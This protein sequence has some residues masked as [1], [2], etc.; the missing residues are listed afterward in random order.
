MKKI[1][2]VVLLTLLTIASLSTS[3]AQTPRPV[4]PP[5]HPSSQ[6]A[7]L[8][9][10]TFG[11]TQYQHQA[12]QLLQSTV[13]SLSSSV[14]V[15]N[16]YQPN[17]FSQSGV[18][19]AL[20]FQSE[21]S[22]FSQTRP[23]L[24]G[25]SGISIGVI[26][27]NCLIAMV[28]KDS[29]CDPRTGKIINLVP[30]PQS[31]IPKLN[32]CFFITLSK[33]SYC[34][35]STGKIKSFFKEIDLNPFGLIPYRC[36]VAHFVDGADCYHSLPIEELTLSEQLT[37]P[38]MYALF[39]NLKDCGQ[40]IQGSMG[41]PNPDVDVEGDF[42]VV[43]HAPEPPKE[44][45]QVNQETVSQS[46]AAAQVHQ[47][48]VQREEDERVRKE[49]AADEANRFAAEQKMRAEESERN[50]EIARK[51]ANSSQNEIDIAKANAA[52]ASADE[53]QRKT[54]IFVTN[55]F[56]ANLQ[57]K[58][59][60][61]KVETLQADAREAQTVADNL[62]RQFVAQQ[63]L[64]QPFVPD[65]TNHGMHG[66]TNVESNFV[67]SYGNLLGVPLVSQTFNIPGTTGTVTKMIPV[68]GII[69]PNLVNYSFRFPYEAGVLNLLTNKYDLALNQLLA[70][71]NEEIGRFKGD[72][73]LMIPRLANILHYAAVEFAVRYPN[74]AIAVTEALDRQGEHSSYSNHYGGSALDLTIFNRLTGS[75]VTDPQILRDKLGGLG[76][77][78]TQLGA[79]FVHFELPNGYGSDHW[80]IHVSTRH[81]YF[82]P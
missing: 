61:V 74:Y 55:V 32:N 17:E 7:N 2:F 81:Y 5:S 63:P 41:M 58:I 26:H 40:V 69:P 29:Y 12:N 31:L 68:G 73:F 21:G 50:A 54:E 44:Q 59:Q 16:Q 18:G 30:E 78:M 46:E 64:G 6:V 19:I 75:K 53:D 28:T 34:D 11:Q 71:K 4:L 33:D 10:N 72:D 38:C 3:L 45:P 8:L 77:I 82:L 76:R 42:T 20:P 60:T 39:N 67:S 49:Q 48:Q 13:A 1:E 27:R 24:T 57:L 43:Y 15:Q 51:Q 65:E 62:V 66:G 79:D 80:H 36:L 37:N 9:T 25:Q 56:I 47:E 52:Q 35:P 23:I 22:L 70:F 14:F